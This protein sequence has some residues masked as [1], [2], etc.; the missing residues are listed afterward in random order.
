M[1]IVLMS[2]PVN[3][4]ARKLEKWVKIKYC[5]IGLKLII[6]QKNKTYC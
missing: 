3:V 6:R 2:R 4:L 1:D 5:V